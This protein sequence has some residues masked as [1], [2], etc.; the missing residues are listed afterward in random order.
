MLLPLVVGGVCLMWQG[1]ADFIVAKEGSA[2]FRT[3]QAA[4]DA[5]SSDGAV[6]YIRPGTYKERIVVDKPKIHLRG[7]GSDPREVVLTYDLSS[8][9]AGGTFK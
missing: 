8:K 6:I 3:V 4:V 1:A 7:G 9:T 2:D 5:A